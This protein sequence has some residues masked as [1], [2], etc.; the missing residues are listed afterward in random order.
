MARSETAEGIEHHHKDFYSSENPIPSIQRFLHHGIGAIVAR[1]GKS[2]SEDE[3]R[4]S[5]ESSDSDD[6]ENDSEEAQPMETSKPG[7]TSSDSQRHHRRSSSRGLRKRESSRRDTKRST[8]SD[9]SS[10]QREDKAQAG[11]EKS[12]EERAQQKQQ[13][14]GKRSGSRRRGQAVKVYDPITQKTTKVRDV[15][16]RDFQREIDKD[17][18]RQKGKPY[19][20]ADPPR[21][22]MSGIFPPTEPLP[23]SIL[24]ING[25]LLPIWIVWSAAL[26]FC[27]GLLQGVCLAAVNAWI[28]WYAFRRLQ[29]TAEDRRWQQE[30]ERGSKA[31]QGKL[32]TAGE[33]AGKDKTE[34]GMKE[35]AEWLNNIV[36]SLWEIIDPAIFDSM[37]GTLEDVMQ[38][39]APS[40]IHS[41]KV[42]EVSH[43]LTPIRI[44]GVKILSDR[45]ADHVTPPSDD[46]AEPNQ[47]R[48][49]NQSSSRRTYSGKHI[50]LE[51]SVIY[52]ASEGGANII[53]RRKNARLHMSFWL[54]VRKVATVPFP[55]V[56]EI[57]GFVGTVRARLQLTPA[58]PFIKNTTVTFLGLPRVAV[59]VIP[60]GVNLANVPYLSSFVQSSIDAAF[61]EYCAPSSLTLDVGEI[62]MGDNIKREVNALGVIVVW[63]HSATELEKQDR[64]GLSDPYVT[65]SYSR[66]GKV[67]YAT[68]VAMEDL[69][70]RWEERHVMLLSPE[71]VRAKEKISV[72]L[73]DS[74]RLTADDVLGRVELDLAPLLFNPGKVFKRNDSLM[75]ISNQHSKEGQLHWSVAFFRKVSSHLEDSN[76]PQQEEQAKDT[77]T[78]RNDC[79]TAQQ[80]RTNTNNDQQEPTQHTEPTA[81]SQEH[82]DDFLQS[83]GE[84]TSPGA[85]LRMLDAAETA[86]QTRNQQSKVEFQSPNSGLPSGIL[87]I[88]VHHITDLAFAGDGSGNKAKGGVGSAAQAIDD[89]ENQNEA[90]DAPSSYVSIVLND[91][92]VMISRVKALSNAPFFNIGTE[93]FVRDW[94]RCIIM[95][96]VRDR[97][98]RE[99]D[100]ILGVIPIKL[101]EL[102]QQCGTS[103]VTQ[104]MPMAGGIGRG[105]VRVSLLFRPV[106]GMHLS[107]EKLGFDIGTMRVH[108][109][110][111]V[112]DLVDHTLRGTSI[113]MRTL[114]GQV[115]LS[116]RHSHHSSKDNCV[117]WRVPSSKLF[118]RVPARRRY[119]APF[120]FE[121]RRPNAVG[122]KTLVAASIIWL[123]D[124]P[125]DETIEA[126][127]PVYK[128]DPSLHRYLQNYHDYTKEEEALEL[129]VKRVGTLKVRLQFKSGIGPAH[130]ELDGNPDSKAVMDAWRACV[131]AGMRS[132]TGDFTMEDNG[133]VRHDDEHAQTDEDNSDGKSS[134]E[135][136]T[137]NR[138]ETNG[139]VEESDGDDEE[140]D[141]TTTF[142][143]KWNKWKAEQKEMRRQ[144]R[145]VNS[146]KAVRT[147]SW[148]VSSARS[149]GS[150]VK[151]GLTVQE[152]SRQHIDSEL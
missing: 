114:A 81:N 150:K 16:K 66:L 125:D 60:L 33:E 25:N 6:S 65:V 122:I 132:T 78:R 129:G 85:L 152:R 26:L 5:D 80:R 96:V 48:N 10:T 99:A 42:S 94:R 43:G 148:L 64:T 51:M 126:S 34:E 98:L 88:Q 45:E 117:E 136:E 95:V 58:A 135:E 115:K 123:Q 144:H 59:E 18:A 44:A 138:I 104:Y 119:S 82:C 124:C 71:A 107:K 100:P 32:S 75:G 9:A 130:A 36:K 149:G 56:V 12:P 120:V 39:S 63:I 128:G 72:A 8:G 91:Q 146:H 14:Q 55:V 30:E 52:H 147:A 84:D 140:G 121:F 116:S 139:N 131:A 29:R 22:V 67:T 37:A 68:R 53:S 112:T 141:D 54:G 106:E 133:E 49:Q 31:T 113:R 90:P 20:D 46:D 89:K 41:I 11:E 21:N 92:T 40:F 27:L 87:S 108:T 17:S 1:G 28:A 76:Q 47:D 24:E 79:D 57:K 23:H 97:R 19:Q 105:S 3:A 50:N 69:S 151:R 35:G 101:S 137:N 110:P 74:D 86:E 7:S 102:F 2:L 127:L 62:L 38:A 111:C 61:N 93:R 142:A 143:A 77:H 70:P 134:S 103:Q 15:R 109:S 13:K 73:W 83:M 145:G 118:L 4:S